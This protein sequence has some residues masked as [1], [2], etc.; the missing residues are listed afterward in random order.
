[1]GP[2]FSGPIRRL[3]W[4]AAL[5]F[6]FAFA[7]ALGA[8][9]KPEKRPRPQRLDGEVE[10]RRDSAG[11][12]RLSNR[13]LLSAKGKK[14]KAAELPAKNS[15]PVSGT[16]LR[17]QVSLV[18]VNCNVLRPDGA[19]VR[20]LGADSFRIFEDGVE[21]H[22][23][24]FDASQ[25]P[26]SLVLVLDSS[27]SVLPD[28]AEMKR[29]ARA[30]AARLS[31]VDEVAVVAFGSQTLLL[32]P[33]TTDRGKLEQ[34]IDSITLDLGQG[35]NIY[36][37]VYLAARVVFR[38][39]TGR[40]ALILVTDGQ[41]SGLGLSWPPSSALPQTGAGADR[42]SFEDVAR[43]LAEEGIAFDVVSTQN[44][45]PAMTPVWIAA[46]ASKTL[47]TEES[48]RLGI[49]HYTLYLAEMVRRAGGSLYFLH[50]IGTLA[51]VYERIAAELRAQ[52]TLGY[53][54]AGAGSEGWRALR[55]TVEPPGNLALRHRPAYYVPATR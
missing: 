55:V 5:F 19:H 37:A 8:P 38:G 33:F 22:I 24:H 11:E 3:A 52:Y 16:V 13:P 10:L 47:L 6:L 2:A 30:L 28:L 53:Y 41:D 43:T 29:A 35:S 49:P 20:G 15:A 48:R 31:P 14:S 42:L 44:R 7:S 12:L 36:E 45:P 25:E 23:A 26:A 21:Q 18:E 1:M 9:Q 51:E 40:K 32:L 4:P 54:P 50:E 46:H 39:R 17:A 27:P 34:A